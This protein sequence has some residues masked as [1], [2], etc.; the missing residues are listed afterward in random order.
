M[1]LKPC[2]KLTITEAKRHFFPVADIDK[3][4]GKQ[5]IDKET[6]QP[7]TAMVPG[8]YRIT[9]SDGQWVSVTTNKGITKFSLNKPGSMIMD[10]AN[11]PTGEREKPTQP[12]PAASWERFCEAY[13]RAGL[14]ELVL[15]GMEQADEE[16]EQRRA[17]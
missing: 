11:R 6:G 3:K 8:G 1:A 7:K 5:K 4:T 17:A 2:K 13:E 16:L 14:P 12:F 9:L 15:A 10:W